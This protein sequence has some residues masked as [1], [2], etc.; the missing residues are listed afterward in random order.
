MCMLEKAPVSLD[1]VLS[2]AVIDL[3]MLGMNKLCDQPHTLH[4][5]CRH[6]WWSGSV[7]WSTA[8]Q[9]LHPCSMLTHVSMHELSSYP[10]LFW[11]FNALHQYVSPQQP[12]PLIPCIV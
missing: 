2:F 6:G 10:M 1:S 7:S 12:P 11:Q 3:I 9:H 4:E 5:D 8:Q